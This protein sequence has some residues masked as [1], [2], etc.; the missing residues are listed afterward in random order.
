[1][2]GCGRGGREQLGD[3]AWHDARWSD[4]IADYRAAGESPRLTAKLADAALQGGVLTMSAQAWTRL[5]ADAPERAAEAAAGLARVASAALQV[6]DD[7]GLAQAIAG[8]RRVAPGWPLQRL[9]ARQGRIGDL[10]PAAAADV[11]PALLSSVSDRATAEPLLLALGRADR[12]RGACDVAVPILEGV[13]RTTTNA[14]LRDSATTTL[15]WCELGIGLAALAAQHPGDAEHWLGRAVQ[16]DSN[17]AVGRRAMLGVGDARASEGDSASARLAWQAVASAPVP[18]DSITQLAFE[19][20][21]QPAPAAPV[22]TSAHLV[23]P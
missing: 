8:L 9:A 12:A 17:G 5:A 7:A 18:T 11:I 20:L 13:L 22:D 1:M 14:T 10:Q 3:E 4:A 15:S 23:H 2:T 21:S 6:G 19:R 16:R